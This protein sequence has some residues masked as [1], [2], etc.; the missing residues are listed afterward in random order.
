MQLVLSPELILEAYRQGLFPM[1]YNAG[2]P[3]VHWICPDARGQLSISELHLSASLKK[4]LRKNDFRITVDKAFNEVIA[5]CAEARDERPETWINAEI[6]KVFCE[7]H[8]RGLAHSVE[9]WHGR[10]LV[11]GIYGLEIGAAFFGESMFSRETNAS[12]IAL[13]NLIARCWKGGFTLFDTQFV[14]DHLKQ[15]G[16][17]ELEH[18][19]YKKLLTPAIKRKADF[20][21]D[22]IRQEDILDEYLSFRSE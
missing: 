22:G 15:F 7:L 8:E 16:V 3:F 18:A 21:L 2:S 9:C 14:N 4:A 11:G 10:E 1:A 20:K 19:Q 17:Y 5:G 6:M 13:V 12:K